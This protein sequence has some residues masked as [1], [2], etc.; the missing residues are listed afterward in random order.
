[1]KLF[2]QAGRLQIKGRINNLKVFW[3]KKGDE[4][5][6]PSKKWHLTGKDADIAAAQKN[7]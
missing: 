1:M 5:L 4:L 6:G 2:C 7:L 3:G